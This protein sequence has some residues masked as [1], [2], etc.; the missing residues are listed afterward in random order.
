MEDFE[1][2]GI[3]DNW[4]PPDVWIEG[5]HLTP[6]EN[7]GPVITD[8]QSLSGTRSITGLWGTPPESRA[9]FGAEAPD[10][11]PDNLSYGTLTLPHI[12]NIWVYVDPDHE[13]D[14]PTGWPGGG[15]TQPGLT[16]VVT[17]PGQEDR[18][19]SIRW[20]DVLP[21]GDDFHCFRVEGESLDVSIPIAQPGWFR[22]LLDVTETTWSGSVSKEDGTVVAEAFGEWL[23]PLDSESLV[24]HLIDA[25]PGSFMDD[26]QVG[27]P[28]GP[29]LSSHHGDSCIRFLVTGAE[30]SFTVQGPQGTMPFADVHKGAFRIFTSR[31]VPTVC[32]QFQVTA[33]EEWWVQTE[34]QWFTEDPLGALVRGQI[35]A[36]GPR[37]LM[38]VPPDAEPGADPWTQ[39]EIFKKPIQAATHWQP[40]LRFYATGD[41]E[42]GPPVGTE[43]N[44]DCI[45]IPESGRPLIGQ[46]YLDGDQPFG[47]WDGYPRYS[48]SIFGAKPPP[49]STLLVIGEGFVIQPGSLPP[50]FLGE[51]LTP[52]LP[53]E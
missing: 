25:S 27:L 13:F 9:S 46:P 48:S 31:R 49:I 15:G 33:P 17:N 34:I 14:P 42:D 3:G 52:P 12:A 43:I 8:E 11:N 40:R 50:F 28:P 5:V 41:G 53:S 19:I 32:G 47:K 30:P 21:E 51:G 26:Y 16:A 44:I 18:V 22:Y 7:A 29:T 23:E 2:Y 1:D 45:Y 35:D 4:S 37:V 6:A 39:V 24:Y 10:P 38:G 20:D 36:V